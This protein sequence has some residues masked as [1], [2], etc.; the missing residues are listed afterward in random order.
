METINYPDWYVEVKNI[1]PNR[2]TEDF[3]DFM[4]TSLEDCKWKNITSIGGWFWIFEM[5]VAKNWWNVI[6]VDPVFSD[7]QHVHNKINE[8]IGRLKGK[9]ETSSRLFATLYDKQ[10]N[11]TKWQLEKRKKAE[12]YRK[13]QETLLYNLEEREKNQIKYNL[14]LNASSGDNIQWIKNESQDIVMINHTL[15]HITSKIE[16]RS[17]IVKSMLS[18]SLRIMKKNWKFWIVDYGGSIWWLWEME[19][20]LKE[21]NKIWWKTKCWSFSSWFSKKWLEMFIK[22]Y[23]N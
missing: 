22:Q 2:L 18:E 19:T 7:K 23:F 9:L 6:V 1:C 4:E 17:T 11:P 5:D 12:W 15:N 13:T 10:K 3:L 16:N 14:S 21:S 20:W 8:N